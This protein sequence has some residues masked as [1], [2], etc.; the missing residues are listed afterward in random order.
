MYTQ[1][2]ISTVYRGHLYRSRTEAM[3][4]KF[5]HLAGIEA[6]HERR[7]FLLPNGFAYLPDFTLPR[8]GMAVEIKP[9]PKQFGRA[10]ED[11]H[12][13][14]MKLNGDKFDEARAMLL[15]G[16]SGR[17][18]GGYDCWILSGQPNSPVI[19]TPA[20]ESI[21][22]QRLLPRGDVHLGICAVCKR[23]GLYRWG[24][25][26]LPRVTGRPRYDCC[27]C[28]PVDLPGTATSLFDETLINNAV[29]LPVCEARKAAHRRHDLYD[30]E[31][32]NPSRT[33][34]AYSDGGARRLLTVP[35]DPFKTRRA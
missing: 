33:E 4:G 22:F 8:Q 11:M 13:L 27:F 16:E 35:A 9:G 25:L 18:Q 10:E 6:E 20:V 12:R 7:R 5:F 19:Y 21:Y 1:K 34:W 17:L 23:L 28:G 14:W 2:P 24:S 31:A 32:T 26:A 15:R 3:W 30:A 29:L